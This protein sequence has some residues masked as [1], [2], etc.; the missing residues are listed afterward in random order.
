MLKA[1]KKYINTGNS[2]DEQSVKRRYECKTY[3]EAETE[4]PVRTTISAVRDVWRTF[5]QS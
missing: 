1:P 4:H 3:A 2:S 5:Y